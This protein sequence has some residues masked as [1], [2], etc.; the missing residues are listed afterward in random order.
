[1][2]GRYFIL[3]AAGGRAGGQAR[4]ELVWRAGGIGGPA[5]SQ[6]GSL[7][8]LLAAGWRLAARHRPSSLLSRPAPPTRVWSARAGPVCAQAGDGQEEDELVDGVLLAHAVVGAVAKG[9]EVLGVHNVLLAL[10]THAVWVKPLGVGEALGHEGLGGGHGCSGRGGRQAGQARER[11][12]LRAGPRQERGTSRHAWQIGTLFRQH[13]HR[14]RAT[15]RRVPHRGPHLHVGCVDGG[16][17]EGAARDVVLLRQRVVGVGHL[18]YHGG[19][20]AVPQDL[21]HHLRH[22]EEGGRVGA[23]GGGLGR[24]GTAREARAQRWSVARLRMQARLLLWGALASLAPHRHP[25]C[26]PPRPPNPPQPS[27]APPPHPPGAYRPSLPAPQ[28]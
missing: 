27:P 2:V 22:G 9:E 19:G 7:R 17:D 26:L 6:A 10:G 3:S 28:R 14:G 15:P 25:A 8:T 13:R 12:A 23:G 1:M 4:C 21:L 5:P 20:G 16:E 24:E 11:W 18:R